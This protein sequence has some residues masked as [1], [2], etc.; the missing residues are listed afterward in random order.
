MHYRT[1][2]ETWRGINAENRFHRIAVALLLLLLLTN[3]LSLISLVRADR[4]VVLVP[5]ILEGQV[6]VARANAHH[7]R[8]SKSPRRAQWAIRWVF[9]GA[10]LRGYNGNLQVD[11]RSNHG[12]HTTRIIRAAFD[13]FGRRRCRSS[14]GRAFPDHVGVMSAVG[15]FRSLASRPGASG[16]SNKPDIDCPSALAP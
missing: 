15:H 9:S 6:N 1:L 11:T 5:P 13:G 10:A 14:R 16:L 4:T 3:L 2:T 12:Q 7:R 8:P